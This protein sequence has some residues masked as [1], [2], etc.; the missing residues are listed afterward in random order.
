MSGCTAHRLD[1]GERLRVLGSMLQ[2]D[3]PFYL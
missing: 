2:P 3:E 1:R